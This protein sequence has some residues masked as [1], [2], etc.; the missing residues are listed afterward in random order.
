MVILGRYCTLQL[1]Q[2]ANSELRWL[3]RPFEAFFTSWPREIGVSA[4]CSIFM[5]SPYFS[6]GWKAK[7]TSNLQ[8]ILQK[9][10]LRRLSFLLPSINNMLQTNR[11]WKNKVGLRPRMNS[12]CT[13]HFEPVELAVFVFT[14]IEG[15][16]SSTIG[17]VLNFIFNTCYWKACHEKIHS[18]S[19]LSITY[20]AGSE[21]KDRTLARKDR[22][23]YEN[24]TD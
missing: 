21:H 2:R 23:L 3:F 10:L 15:N 24:G 9:C 1:P 7:N 4:K 5:S 20:P 12:V 22:W 8:K 14:M 13:W 16:K 19:C 11:L 18:C 17:W 6:R